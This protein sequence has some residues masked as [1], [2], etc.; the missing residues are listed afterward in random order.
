MPNPE[1]EVD[2]LDNDSIGLDW[3][4]LT[5]RRGRG[6]KMNIVDDQN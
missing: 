2:V 1:E 6:S 4:V 5:L 3:P